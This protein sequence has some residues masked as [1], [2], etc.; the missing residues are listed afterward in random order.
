MVHLCNITG[1]V[2]VGSCF[3]AWSEVTVFIS[4]RNKE[5]RTLY[6]LYCPYFLPNIMVMFTRKVSEHFMKLIEIG[7]LL[8]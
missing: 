3:L 5:M 1:S 4:L 6:D 2:S 7:I 8:I